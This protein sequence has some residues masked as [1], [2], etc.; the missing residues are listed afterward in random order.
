MARAGRQESIIRNNGKYRANSKQKDSGR[1]S[2]RNGKH[3]V[4]EGLK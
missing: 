4:W 3:N 1:G 2:E